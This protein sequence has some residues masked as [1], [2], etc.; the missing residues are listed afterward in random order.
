MNN[1]DR[2]RSMDNQQMAE[3]IV[4]EIGC[5]PFCVCENS[6]SKE[7]CIELIEAPDDIADEW[8]IQCIKSHLDKEVEK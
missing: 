5:V 2:F 6:P 8:C 4:K 3:F 7:Q 1:G